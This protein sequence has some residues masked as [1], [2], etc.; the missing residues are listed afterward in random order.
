MS[1]EADDVLGRLFERRLVMATGSLEGTLVDS[2][3]AQLLT[4][5][6]EG[7]EPIEVVID[8][9]DADLDAAF[10]LLDVC[11]S[12]AAPLSFMVSGR[13]AG[14]GV[15]L[16]TTAHRRRGRP[17]A[18]LQL[19][20][21]RLEATPSGPGSLARLVEEHRRRVGVL[22]D[23]IAERT[24]RPAPLVADEMARGVY[25]T[26]EQAVTY[27]LLDEVAHRQPRD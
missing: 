4:L 9:P 24:S 21:P 23:R 19:A 12:L 8:C 3:A 7:D 1:D 27:G 22:I 20:E 6:A 13:L 10:T 15:V 17:H 2:V 11:E 5:D 26:S 25:L 16:L 18:I 14:A